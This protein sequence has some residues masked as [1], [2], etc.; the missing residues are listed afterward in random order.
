MA[1]SELVKQTR[2]D[3]EGGHARAQVYLGWWHLGGLE[4]LEQDDV[5][6]AAWFLKAADLGDT[7]S[8]CFLARSYQQG[9]G[10]EQN[11]TLAAEWGRK[12]AD[13]GHAAAQ[14]FVG[15]WYARGDGVKKNLPLGK[16]YLELS[17]AQGYARAVALLK[18]LRKC[19][20]CGKL[21]VHHMICK[22]CHNRRYCD[23]T[24]QLRHWN[25]LVD[26]HKLHCVKRRES[27]GA[28]ASSSALVDDRADNN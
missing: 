25:S 16:R 2:R 20:A 3:A 18:E 14:L 4:G 28:G 22:R 17:A 23:R 9:V 12:A 11:S 21:D 13:Q 15:E 1:P 24:C 7:D 6:A 19:V 5:K 27:A 8:Q 26:P 10:V